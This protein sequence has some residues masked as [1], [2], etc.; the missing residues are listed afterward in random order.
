M[1]PYTLLTQVFSG[2]HGLCWWPGALRCTRYTL[3]TRESTSL[4]HHLV[5]AHLPGAVCDFRLSYGRVLSRSS[6]IIVV[7][8]DRK[9]M[10]LNS[11]MFWKPREAVQGQC[12]HCLHPPRPPG[13]SAE[14]SWVGSQGHPQVITS[15]ELWR[16]GDYWV[17]CSCV[18]TPWRSRAPSAP[19]AVLSTALAPLAL[20]C[21]WWPLSWCLVKSPGQEGQAWAGSCGSPE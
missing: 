12:Q 4:A 10:L 21:G 9:E 8:R 5:L 1:W 11:D 20:S 2:L 7:N 19:L 15:V 3:G 6:Q 13:P 14:S 17:F 18:L 16:V